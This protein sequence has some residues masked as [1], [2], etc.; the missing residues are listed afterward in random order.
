MEGWRA[1][2]FPAGLTAASY[3]PFPS[4]RSWLARQVVLGHSFILALHAAPL[5]PLSL[6]PGGRGGLA[7]LGICFLNKT[8]TS[9]VTRA[10]S[11]RLL[12]LLF[13]SWPLGTVL[14]AVWGGGDRDREEDG[15]G[16]AGAGTDCPSSVASRTAEPPPS[17]CSSWAFLFHVNKGQR[18]YSETPRATQITVSVSHVPASWAVFF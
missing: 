14:L 11:D 9:S 3:L 7:L 8:K 1:V 15:E 18:K 17:P 13:A 12:D 4:L 5:L 6:F 16:S 2:S 10:S